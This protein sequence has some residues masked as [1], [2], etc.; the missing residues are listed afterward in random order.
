MEKIVMGIKALVMAASLSLV[1]TGAL[2]ASAAPPQASVHRAAA[3]RS[4][5][6]Q[7]GGTTGWFFAV[8]IAVALVWGGLEL[9]GDD[10]D[11]PTSP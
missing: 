8:I 9:L 6:S 3:E 5:T 1:S 10:N 7:L 11:T 4:E 2:A